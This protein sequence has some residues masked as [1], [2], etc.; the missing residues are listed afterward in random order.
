MDRWKHWFENYNEI[1]CCMLKGEGA[2]GITISIAFAGETNSRC[3]SKD[4]SLSTK[5]YINYHFKINYQVM[6]E[7]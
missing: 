1:S 7:K 4:D 6:E 3:W 5:Y 2:K